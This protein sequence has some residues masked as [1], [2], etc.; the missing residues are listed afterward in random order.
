MAI[1]IPIQTSNPGVEVDFFAVGN[2]SR[3]G[4]AIVVRLG[5]LHGPVEQQLIIVVD[6]GFTS[7]GDA[8]VAH[9]REVVGTDH[10]DLVISTHPDTDHVTGL[11]RV[12]EEMDV[13][14]LWMHLPW[15]HTDDIARM[16]S[17]GRVTDNSI[18]NKLRDELNGAA[19]LA[20][21]ALA[22][23]VR[24]IEPFTGL[25]AFDSTIQIVGPDLDF[26]EDLLLDFRSTPDRAP[27]RKSILARAARKIFESFGI[28]TLTDSG[29]T[30]AENNTSAITLFTVGDH[31]ILLTGDAGIPALERAATKLELLGA[32][33]NLDFIQVPHHGGRHNV[34]PTVLDRIIGH[35]LNVDVKRATAF[36]S[37]APDGEPDHPS[38][39]VTN[40]FRRRGAHVFATQGTSH[41]HSVNA[42]K[43]NGWSPATPLPFFDEIDEEEE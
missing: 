34:G 39:Q 30:S 18:S 26:Y 33:Q 28:E 31:R 24:V 43:R 41:R 32:A 1:D 27:V 37:A 13:D 7:D 42:P 22:R 25:S 15:K 2:G 35:R 36:V 10:V 8:I 12:L 38:R 5:N 17:D 4:D 20:E 29:H 40:A 3:S 9:L 23:G 16:F 21:T 11:R 19:E 14:E 6:G